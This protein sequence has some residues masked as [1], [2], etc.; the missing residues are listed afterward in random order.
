M[1]ILVIGPAW[2]GDMVMAQS[3]FMCLKQQHPRARIDVLA[4]AWSAALLNRMPEVNEA[5]TLDIAHGELGLMKRYKLGMALRERGYDQAIV[6]PNSF[7]SALI[8]LIAKIPVR[9]GWRGEARGWLLNDCRKLDKE[10]YPLMVQRFAALAY[11]ETPAWLLAGRVAVPRLRVAAGAQRAT[12]QRLRLNSPK[13]ILALCPGAEYGPSKQWPEA[14]YAAVAAHYLQPQCGYQVVML[15]SERDRPVAERIMD[16]LKESARADC[17]NLCGETKLSEAID[18]LGAASAVVTN[19]SGLM[20]VAAALNRPMVVVYGST[21]AD[22]TPPLSAQARALS[23]QMDCSPCFKREC[24]LGH[25]NCLK[26]LTPALVIAALAELFSALDEEASGEEY[27]E[28]DESDMPPDMPDM[29][30]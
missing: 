9:T 2:V 11:K 28:Y 13:P 15:G 18:I 29:Q 1:K 17:H 7:K 20:H 8:P 24:P 14:H 19:D 16:G 6:L 23:L 25:Q 5:I 12:F 30:E 22:F 3:M 21:S 27:E 10:K 26:E 4:P